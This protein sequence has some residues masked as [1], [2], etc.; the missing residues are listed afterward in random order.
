MA[1][2]RE[3]DFE[4]MGLGFLADWREDWP[5]WLENSARSLVVLAS[6]AGAAAGLG[7]AGPIGM[8]GGAAVGA[9]VA[10]PVSGP[11]ILMLCVTGAG[12]KPLPRRIRR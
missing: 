3:P 1:G 11:V 12:R 2:W 7:S 8:V 10:L 6:I 5:F 4:R 9:L